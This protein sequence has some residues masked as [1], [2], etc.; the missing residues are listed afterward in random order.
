MNI[1][2]VNFSPDLSWRDMQHIVA[3]GARIPS[4]ER[5]VDCTD[6]KNQGVGGPCDPKRPKQNYKWLINGGGYHTNPM[7]GFGLLNCGRMVQLALDWKTVP[8]EHICKTPMVEVKR[9]VLLLKWG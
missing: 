8:E 3:E 2:F 4:V 6:P 5:H 1:N 9:L 7:F